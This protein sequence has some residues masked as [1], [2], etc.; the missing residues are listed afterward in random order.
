[1]NNN[2]KL[3]ANILNEKNNLI[4]SCLKLEIKKSLE[5]AEVNNI[6]NKSI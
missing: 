5:I 2:N 3:K 4:D 6:L 1:M